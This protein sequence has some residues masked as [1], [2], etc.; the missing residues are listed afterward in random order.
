MALVVG[1]S[2][3]LHLIPIKNATN[4]ANDMA[5][6]LSKLGFSVENLQDPNKLQLDVTI[7]KIAG[8]IKDSSVFLF[9]FS[10]H[11]FSYDGD[12]Y[13]LLPTSNPHAEKDLVQ[14]SCSLSDILRAINRQAKLSANVVFLDAGRI[15]LRSA[16]SDV[17]FFQRQR[18][19]ATYPPEQTFISYAAAS[20][21]P[22]YGSNNRR[23]SYY[24]EALLKFIQTPNLSLD[25]LSVLVNQEVKEMTSGRQIP[26]CISTMNSSF[27]FVREAPKPSPQETPHSESMIQSV[28]PPECIRLR[29]MR[30]AMS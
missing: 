26:C 19:K 28:I 4:D 21:S 30:I 8:S 29:N 1:V 11:G 18:L 17:H 5:I 12:N 14:Q 3:Y 22:S 9:Y 6:A 15:P 24:T 10:G 20:G 2:K 16:R 25:Q 7:K 27:Y 23:N 13:L